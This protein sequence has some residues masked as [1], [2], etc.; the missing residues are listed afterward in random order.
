MNRNFSVALL[1]IFFSLLSVLVAAQPS[2]STNQRGGVYQRGG[3]KSQQKSGQKSQ[4]KSA[5]AFSPEKMQG[6]MGLFKIDATAFISKSKISDAT[7]KSRVT[8]VIKGYM[9]QYDALRTRY[10]LQLDSLA[11]RAQAPA[12]SAKP[13]DMRA[14]MQKRMKTIALV[15]EGTLPM[16]SKLIEAMEVL[17]EGKEL[18]MWNMYYSNL[19][20][21]NNF[22]KNAR[23]QVSGQKE[24]PGVGQRQGPVGGQRKGPAG[25]QRGNV[26]SRPL[27]RPIGY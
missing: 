16:H 5:Q 23:P 12:S 25:G 4:Q 19:C 14:Q 15:R 27:G 2:R 21:K 1:L 7:K 6:A 26:G 11:V 20:K 24:G 8:A 22:N 17:L 3:Q 10:A 9:K 18:Q 13:T